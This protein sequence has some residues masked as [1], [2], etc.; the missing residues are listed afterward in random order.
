MMRSFLRRDFYLE[1]LWGVTSLSALGRSLSGVLLGN[2][3]FGMPSGFLGPLWKG[4][5]VSQPSHPGLSIQGRQK[6]SP[7]RSPF[8]PLDSFT[9]FKSMAKMVFILAMNLTRN[10]RGFIVV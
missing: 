2:L 6:L 4:L 7:F 1:P 9:P 8:F 10:Q 3:R 5:S